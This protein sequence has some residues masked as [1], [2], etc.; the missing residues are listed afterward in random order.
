MGESSVITMCGCLPYCIGAHLYGVCCGCEV[1]CGLFL[2]VLS[3][4]IPALIHIRILA[5]KYM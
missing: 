1:D 2:L 5:R 3:L 4:H